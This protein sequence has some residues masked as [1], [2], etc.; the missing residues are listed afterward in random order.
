MI[1]R[2]AGLG[3]RLDFSLPNGP[4]VKLWAAHLLLDPETNSV[5]SKRILAG[6]SYSF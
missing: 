4:K 3:Y 5:D 2:F 1:K 6:L